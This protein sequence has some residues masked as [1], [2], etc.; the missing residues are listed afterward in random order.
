VGHDHLALLAA[1]KLADNVGRV[2]V[3][4]E[5]TG[6]IVI[7]ECDCCCFCLSGLGVAQHA[8]LSSLSSFEARH[9]EQ[10]HLALLAAPK[11]AA[12]DNVAADE[13]AVVVDEED[14]PSWR[15]LLQL[16]HKFDDAASACFAFLLGDSASSFSPF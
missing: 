15:G 11:L 3:V 1:P 8:H 13:V 9:V 7:D 16:K 2:V 5:V 10:D 12:S 14:P 4:V 6:A